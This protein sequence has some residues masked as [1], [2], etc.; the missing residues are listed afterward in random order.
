MIKLD[1][2]LLLKARKERHSWPGARDSFGLI[3]TSVWDGREWQN[4]GQLWF[5]KVIFQS[6]KA[7]FLFSQE[8]VCIVYW[9]CFIGISLKYKP[10]C[11]LMQF[12]DNFHDSLCD[13][14]HGKCSINIKDDLWLLGQFIL[15]CLKW[16]WIP[17]SPCLSTSHNLQYNEKH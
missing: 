8:T 14:S 15:C 12:V 3:L 9:I 6:V 17:F 4:S 16:N 2:K 7:K 5:C 10:L 11:M 13:H 1:S